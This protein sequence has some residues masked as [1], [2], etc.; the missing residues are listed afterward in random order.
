MAK[1][2]IPGVVCIE[3]ITLIFII[4]LLIGVLYFF[5]LSNKPTQ[6]NYF[7]H[8]TTVPQPPILMPISSKQD[9]F[10][11]PY[12]PPLKQNAHIHPTDS[13]DIRGIPINIETRAISSSYQQ[14]GILNRTNDNSDLIL[15]LMGKR[16]MSGRDK[17]QYYT[18]SGSGN[19]NTRLPI[20]VNGKNCSGEYG[21]DE[22]YNGDVVYVEGYNDTFQATIYNNDSP[23]Y[24]PVL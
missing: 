16:T 15:P 23:H 5:Y 18:I 17:W 20:S 13:S 22:I 19:L 9:I 14:I 11:D 24:L 12:R 6:H 2:C 21:C 1:K 8:E 4:L 3:N 7:R 10:N